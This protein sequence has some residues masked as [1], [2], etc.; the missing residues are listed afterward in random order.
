MGKGSTVK[1]QVTSLFRHKDGRLIADTSAGTRDQ[2]P[3]TLY[4]H[5]DCNA[6]WNRFHGYHGPHTDSII[7]FGRRPRLP[8]LPGVSYAKMADQRMTA[9]A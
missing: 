1:N 8:F 6:P 4:I 3:T 2:C 7:L 9:P 5:H